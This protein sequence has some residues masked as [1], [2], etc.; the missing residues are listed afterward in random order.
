LKT[1]LHDFPEAVIHYMWEK[2][3]QSEQAMTFVERSAKGDIVVEGKSRSEQAMTFVER[4]AKGDIVVE[5]K[6][7]KVVR[8]SNTLDDYL[9]KMGWKDDAG[10]CMQQEQPWDTKAK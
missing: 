9:E 2:Y 5:G 6:K 7:K 10:P 4:S 8:G 3:S 1:M